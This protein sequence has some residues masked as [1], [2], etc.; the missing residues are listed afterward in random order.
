MTLE[1]LRKNISELKITYSDESFILLREYMDYVLKMNKEIN[2]TAIEDEETYI[3]KMIYDSVL[4]LTL[5]DFNNK[6]VLDIG[7]GGGYPGT[8]I[9][10]LTNARVD[11]LDSTSKKLNV[12]ASFP[13]KK[14]NTIHARAEEYASNHRETYD[15]VIARAVS[16]LNILLEIAIPLVKVNGYFIAMKGKEAEEEIKQA[17]GAFK[18]LN[19]HIERIDKII[20]PS[21]EERNNILIKKD[22]TTHKKYPREYKD[23]KRLPL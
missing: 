13:N 2:L 3:E 10:T 18:K 20:L 4:P 16:A 17:S 23:I 15:I 14:F 1:E 12:I 21:G 9:D 6:H 8:V 22:K 19:C 7:T 5:L 11:L